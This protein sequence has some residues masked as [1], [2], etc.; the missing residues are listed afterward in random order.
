[1]G[2]RKNVLDLVCLYT[3]YYR[4]FSRCHIYIYDTVN[5]IDI[6]KYK[7]LSSWGTCLG[8]RDIPP[9]GRRSGDAGALGG[10]ANPLSIRASRPSLPRAQEPLVTPRE[11][12]RGKVAALKS[13]VH[14]I[15]FRA[16]PRR[17]QRRPKGDRAALG[18]GR[19]SLLLQDAP[20]PQEEMSRVE[21]FMRSLLSR[22]K[23][24]AQHVARASSLL[25]SQI[26][27][28]VRDPRRFKNTKYKEKIH[29]PRPGSLKDTVRSASEIYLKIQTTGFYCPAT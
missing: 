3:E 7:I 12:A 27:L 6:C 14:L 16:S 13:H 24:F 22:Y 21:L 9:L 1:M 8:A 29:R 15:T 23:A 2:S 20:F 17:P 4:A 26:C 18:T 19:A 11:K 28:I 25:C 10:D 5:I